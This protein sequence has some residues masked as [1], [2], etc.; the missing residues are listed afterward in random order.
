VQNLA[1]TELRSPNRSARGQS[2]FRLRYTGPLPCPYVKPEFIIKRGAQTRLLII[3]KRV[4]IFTIARYVF[5][6][7]RSPSDRGSKKSKRKGVRS[8]LSCFVPPSLD[9][10]LVGLNM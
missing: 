2:L 8:F 1:P 10:D 5:R 4:R 9:G 7:R 3:I 6:T